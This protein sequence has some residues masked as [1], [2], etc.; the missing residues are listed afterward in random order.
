M[1]NLRDLLGIVSEDTLKAGAA[2]DDVSKIARLPSEGY[3][4]QYITAYCGATCQEYNTNYYYM[5]YPNWCAP[6]GVCDIIFE[7]WGGGGGGGSS[8]CCSRGVPGGSGAYAYKRLVGSQYAGCA[9]QIEVGEPGCGRMGWQCGDPGNYT[10]ITGPGLTNFCAD[11]GPAGCSCCFLCC[12]TAHYIS[13]SNCPYGCC[14]CYYGAD[15]GSRGVPGYT[16]MFCYNNHCYNKQ[17]I[18]YPG[19][20]VNG[21]GGW[22]PGNQCENSGCGY[23][24][25]H[26][27][28]DQLHWGGAHS[29]S[30]YVPGV[31]GA[32]GWTCSGGCCHGQNGNP[33]MVRI[34]YKYDENL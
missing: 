9:Y 15:G 23:C 34:S 19:G 32:S 8:C 10:S 3:C 12:C 21:K 17:M 30:N 26:W 5:Q 7:I 16:Y 22:L 29:Q 11:G 20:L 24:L 33:G 28:V 1:S 27:A 6:D 31:G 25:M 13:L 14:A 2:P 4:V 18:A